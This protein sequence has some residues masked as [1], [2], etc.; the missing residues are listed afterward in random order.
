MFLTLERQYTKR[1]AVNHERSLVCPTCGFSLLHNGVCLTL[2]GGNA[3][4]IFVGLDC[5]TETSKETTQN[6]VFTVYHIFFT[7]MLDFDKTIF[8]FM[9]IRP[10]YF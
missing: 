1:C 9:N 4:G 5:K 2:H 10:L 3:K 8:I 6:D 7:L